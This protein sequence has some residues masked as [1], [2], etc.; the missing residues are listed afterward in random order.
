[1]ASTSIHELA[2]KFPDKSYRELEAASLKHQAQKASSRKL[3]APSSKR[4]AS[5]RKRQAAQSKSPH[6]VSR[7]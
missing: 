6:K 3:Q 1:M 2:K 4:Q 5:S 7:R